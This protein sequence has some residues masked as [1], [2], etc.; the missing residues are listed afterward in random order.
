MKEDGQKKTD[1]EIKNITIPYISLTQHNYSFSD[2]EF[3]IV[4]TSL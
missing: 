3:V 2:L 4:F 1:F